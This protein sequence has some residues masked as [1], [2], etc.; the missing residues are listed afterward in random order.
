MLIGL[1]TRQALNL[2][3]S[4]TP[5]PVGFN[6]SLAGPQVQTGLIGNRTNREDG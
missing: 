1:G 4:L 6:V 3:P 5:A 2:M